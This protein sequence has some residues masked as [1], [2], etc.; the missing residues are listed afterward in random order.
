MAVQEDYDGPKCMEMMS[1]PADFEAGWGRG[2]GSPPRVVRR[3][4]CLG[5]FEVRLWNAGRKETSISVHAVMTVAAARASAAIAC[6]TTLRV[7]NYPVAAFHR[8]PSGLTTVVFKPSP[9][10][11]N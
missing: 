11:G 8:R 2:L 5:S 3:S 4:R 1:T 7:N 9:G 10:P 6:N